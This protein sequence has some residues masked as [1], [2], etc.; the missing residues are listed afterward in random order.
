[1]NDRL[2][3]VSCLLL[4]CGCAPAGGPSPDGGSEPRLVAPGVVSTS[5]HENFPAI[6]PVD[7]SLWFSVYDGEA[8]NRQTLVRAPRQGTGWGAPAPVIFPAD[9]RWGARAPRF[10]ADGRTLYFTSNRPRSAGDT[11]TDMNIWMAERT[12]GG[13]SAP[14]VLPA[15][16]NADEPD[17]HAASGPGGDLYLASRRP[18]T[19]GRSDIFRIPRRGQGWGAAEHLPPPVND[20]QSQS[21]LWVSP[22]GSWM[23][24]VVTDHPLGL[25]G[26]DLFIVRSRDGAWSAPEHLPAPINSP[27]YEYGPALSPDGRTLFF[28]SDRGGSADIYQVPVSALGMR[29]GT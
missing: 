14:V 5:R 10:S 29:S 18:G 19:L 8:F 23:I 26:D 28:N 20:A 1:M 9:D 13:W 4:A 12:A 16:V 15:P 6:D 7:G 17:I 3:L 21:D 2:A 24:L 25:G 11:R 27:G 22:D